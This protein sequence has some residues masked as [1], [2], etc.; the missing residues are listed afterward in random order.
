MRQQRS[1]R[2]RNFLGQPFLRFVGLGMGDRPSLVCYRQRDPTED[3]CRDSVL[4]WVQ[5]T[6]EGKM[7]RA[8]YTRLWEFRTRTRIALTSSIRQP[9]RYRRS[10]SCSWTGADNSVPVQLGNREGVEELLS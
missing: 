2:H 3:G 10:K 9:M 1:Q 6:P 5:A 8:A 7:I 4:I